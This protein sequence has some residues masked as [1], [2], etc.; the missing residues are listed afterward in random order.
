MR[1]TTRCSACATSATTRPRLRPRCPRRPAR[2]PVS[3]LSVFSPARHGRANAPARSAGRHPHTHCPRPAS[4]AKRLIPRSVR[5]W[6]LRSGAPRRSRR[7]ACPSRRFQRRLSVP[8][9]SP[10]LRPSARPRRSHHPARLRQGGASRQS[11]GLRLPGNRPRSRFLSR[12][13]A[14]V[15]QAQAGW[16][17]ALGFLTCRRPCCVSQYPPVDEGPSCPR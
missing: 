6:K 7:S 16:P 5:L 4:T 15:L 1:T 3:G 13:G 11:S 10:R 9:C 8:G 12:S 14:Q 17:G 2:L